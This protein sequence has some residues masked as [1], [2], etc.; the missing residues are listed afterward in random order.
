MKYWSIRKLPN[1]QATNN[2]KSSP[3]PTK[4]TYFLTSFMLGPSLVL[5]HDPP[6]AIK[7]GS[8][9]INHDWIITK[10]ADMPVYVQL[11]CCFSTQKHLSDFPQSENSNNSGLADKSGR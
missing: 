5:M 3:K 7:E 4:I 6:S 1:D 9:V 11:P 2:T 10:Q 8:K